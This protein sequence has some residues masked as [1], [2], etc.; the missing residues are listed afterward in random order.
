MLI[1]MADGTEAGFIFLAAGHG[2]ETLAAEDF[3]GDFFALPFSE[4]GFVVEKVDV[5]RG[6]VLE[7]V[8]DAFGF[9]GEVRQTRQA[10]CRGGGRDG[11]CL[12][13]VIQE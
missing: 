11:G 12:Q 1:K 7:E 2:A 6:T 10:G 9:G 3:G 8:N 5:R 13:I 4:L